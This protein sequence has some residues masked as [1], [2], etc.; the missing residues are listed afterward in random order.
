[1]AHT[2]L[3]ASAVA[4]VRVVVATLGSSCRL[5]TV[6]IPVSHNGNDITLLLVR[7]GRPLKRM[8]ALAWAATAFHKHGVYLSTHDLE[9]A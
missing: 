7:Q 5:T 4:A 1:V 6:S 9:A 3:G 2:V 8:A